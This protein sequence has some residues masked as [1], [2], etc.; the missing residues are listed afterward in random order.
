MKSPCSV[1]W[2]EEFQLKNRGITMKKKNW[3]LIIFT[4]SPILPVAIMIVIS[5][6]GVGCSTTLSRPKGPCDINP[7]AGYPPIMGGFNSLPN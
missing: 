2:V 4:M 1:I 6:V 7:A 3:F 5:V